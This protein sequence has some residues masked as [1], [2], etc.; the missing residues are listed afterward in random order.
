MRTAGT[1]GLSFRKAPVVASHG[2]RALGERAGIRE[3]V[4]FSPLIV[5]S[6]WH[7]CGAAFREKGWANMGVK[8][9]EGAIR[10]LPA[11]RLGI[12]DVERLR[13]AV[14]RRIRPRESEKIGQLLTDRWR[15]FDRPARRAL[16]ILAGRGA[17]DLV[18]TKLTPGRRYRT[19]IREQSG[20]TF[21][22]AEHGFLVIDD[23]SNVVRQLHSPSAR[24]DR[25]EVRDLHIE[26]EA[27]SGLEGVAFDRASA[28]LLVVSENSRRVWEMGVRNDGRELALGAPKVL[29]LLPRLSGR[30]NKGW[31]GITVLEGKHAPDR[32]RRILAV[33]EAAP[34]GIGILNRVTLELEAFLELPPA[35]G[36]EVKDLSDITVDP[37]TGRLF[38]LSDEG[39]SIH[40]LELR[41]IPKILGGGPPFEEFGLVYLGTTELGGGRIQ[42]EGLAFD[43]HGDLW[44][45]GE[46]G[47]AL[48]HLA[49][50]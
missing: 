37:K 36:S 23:E 32:K 43:A 19:G 29:G 44:I 33:N 28:S 13:A 50:G 40:E 16:E 24:S 47:Q 21:V 30:G 3:A 17:P 20:I 31:E 25:I 5:P 34:C 10:D 22:S 26:D 27:I 46:L 9:I 4:Y 14:G 18:P 12:E 39:Q 35:I 38:A 11:G 41:R 2:L 6:S 8:K 48:V 1:Y 49:R 7:G 42:A 45:T 15:S